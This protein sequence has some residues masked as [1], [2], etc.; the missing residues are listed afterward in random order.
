MRS[1]T[2]DSIAISPQKPH[3]NIY[4]EA[5]YNPLFCNGA[6]FYDYIAQHEPIEASQ[7]VAGS[8]KIVRFSKE[9]EGRCGVTRSWEDI[10]EDERE[11]FMLWFPVKGRIAIEQDNQRCVADANSFVRAYSKKPYKS[12]MIAEDGQCETYRVEIPTYEI[13]TY[14]PHLARV[15][16]QAVSTRH[17]STAIARETF[18]HLY[19]HG[20]DLPSEVN[21]MFV[22]AAISA[23]SCALEEE[24]QRHVD[25]TNIKNVRLKGL[26][27]YIDNHLSD[28]GLNADRVAFECGISTRYLYLLFKEAEVSF[29][30]YVWGRRLELAYAWLVND[31]AKQ[32]TIEHVA[33]IAG[34]KSVS[35][36]SRVF[37]STYGCSP[38]QAREKEDLQAS[39]AID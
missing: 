28:P 38:C 6:T 20:D 5:S 33:R 36:F 2:Q 11:F 29:H 9:G 18:M 12:E 21:S 7:S 8:L 17:P 35:H 32:Q 13:N 25:E 39:G 24:C 10:R 31:K 16:G 34:F 4:G 22:S 30:N 1:K 14:L 15:A 19:E 37:R 23:M 3:I 27:N 26:F